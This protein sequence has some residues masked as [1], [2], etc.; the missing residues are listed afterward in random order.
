MPSIVRRVRCHRLIVPSRPIVSVVARPWTMHKLNRLGAFVGLHC[1]LVYSSL[2][3]QYH[4]NGNYIFKPK[5][6]HTVVYHTSQLQPT[7]RYFTY[8]NV[9]VYS[10]QNTVTD[11]RRCVQY[12]TMPMSEASLLGNYY[13]NRIPC[14]TVQVS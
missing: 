14:F 7:V 10:T 6:S 13:G 1:A 9:P 5:G 12:R 4:P 2:S 8:Y 11:V 3:P